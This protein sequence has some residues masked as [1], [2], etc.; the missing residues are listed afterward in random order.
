MRRPTKRHWE[1]K[2]RTK[3]IA[4]RMNEAHS[5]CWQTAWR[6]VC[7]RACGAT[8]PR[9]ALQAAFWG[10]AG[11]YDEAFKLKEAWKPFIWVWKSRRFSL[12]NLY[13]CKPAKGEKECIE[14]STKV[15]TGHWTD[16]E[17]DGL[18][19]NVRQMTNTHSYGWKCKEM[20]TGGA[21]RAWRKTDMEWECGCLAC[22]SMFCRLDT[23]IWLQVKRNADRKAWRRRRELG[24]AHRIVVYCNY[25]AGRNADRKFGKIRGAGRLQINIYTCTGQRCF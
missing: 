23:A 21:R 9:R 4:V 24:G 18:Q 17:R 8:C 5:D 3:W 14:E 22:K 11:N 20:Q 16:M 25:T 10:Q 2:I 15:D 19:I 1:L 13:A 7:I 6:P 12:K